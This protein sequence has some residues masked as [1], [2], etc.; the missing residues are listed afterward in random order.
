MYNIKTDFGARGDGRHATEDTLAV[1]T[2]LSA[3][4]KNGLDRGGKLYFP[5]GHYNINSEMAFLE[6]ATE[7]I[8]SIFV[9]GDGCINTV[10][11]FSGCSPGANGISFSSGAHFGV[12]DVEIFGAPADGIYVGK[13]SS[14]SQYSA[15]GH[16][17]NIRI[18]GCGGNGFRMANAYE[19]TGQNI[20]SFANSGNGFQFDGFHTSL[21]FSGL[22]ADNNTIGFVF[23]G[24]TYSAFEALAS[25]SNTK[26]GYAFSNITGVSLNGIGGEQ[27]GADMIRIFSSDVSAIGIPSSAQD[28]H[29]LVFMGLVGYGNSYGHPGTYASL[30]LLVSENGRPIEVKILGASGAPNTDSDRPFIFASTGG[31]ITLHKELVNVSQYTASDYYSLSGGGAVNVTNDGVLTGSKTYDPPSLAN[32]VQTTTT[33][34]VMGATLGD[35]V[36]ASF[37]LDLQ[38][39]Q[40]FAYVS[41]A[42][43]V[44]YCLRNS[45]AAVVNLG[46]GTLRAVVRKHF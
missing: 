41:S 29:G 2:A 30:M 7:S 11:D 12:C 14:G 39:L 1:V 19:I 15:Q 43:T 34:T 21:K 18:Q 31:A 26:Q 46:S 44:T 3:M 45:T 5:K 22:T 42:N 36:D 38:G 16:F 25:D 35:F 6:Y 4:Q 32:N 40:P 20:W 37:S 17:E 24:I 23:N 28:V 13:G 8:H 33:L 10:L 9:N 27:N